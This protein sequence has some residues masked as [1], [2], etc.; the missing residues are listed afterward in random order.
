M[1][2]VRQPCQAVRSLA[3]QLRTTLV[4]ADKVGMIA[5]KGLVHTPQPA[6]TVAMVGCWNEGRGWS[7]AAA[8]AVGVHTAYSSAKGV[9]SL[10]TDR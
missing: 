8:L 3:K 6:S 5:E 2:A 9:H 7:D 10:F 4:A 1:T